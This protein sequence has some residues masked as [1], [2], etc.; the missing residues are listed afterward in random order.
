MRLARRDRRRRPAIH[1]VV[2]GWSLL[3]VLGLTATADAE[4][5]VLILH[6]KDTS[7]RPIAGVRISTE[8]DGSIG[9]PTD[10][11]G[12]TRIRLAPQTQPGHQVT[13]QVVASP[14]QRD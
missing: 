12:K 13:L 10:R 14:P 5:G 3:F 4:K 2:V 1:R 8:G 7:G 6:V 11:A 9:P